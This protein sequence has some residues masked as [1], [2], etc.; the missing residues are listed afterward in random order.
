MQKEHEAIMQRLNQSD[1][2]LCHNLEHLHFL[3]K[4]E[5]DMFIM[6]TMNRS[7][8]MEVRDVAE[9][10]DMWT[11][12]YGTRT[13]SCPPGFDNRFGNATKRAPT[14]VWNIEPSI[15]LCGGYDCLAPAFNQAPIEQNVTKK[16]FD[17]QTKRK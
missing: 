2:I 9:E 4:R 16:L 5:N 11:Q 14:G 12:T 6:S 15:P 13:A 17:N 1:A 10:Y 7:L 3:S 8:P